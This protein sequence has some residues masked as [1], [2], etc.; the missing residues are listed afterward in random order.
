MMEAVP[1]L[2][3]RSTSSRLDGAI[4][5]KAIIFTVTSVRTLNL[6]AKIYFDKCDSLSFV[7]VSVLI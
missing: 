6:T 3:C 7:N 4:F 1:T 5:Q 2:K